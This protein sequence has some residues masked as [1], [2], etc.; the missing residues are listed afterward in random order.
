MEPQPIETI[1]LKNGL[2]L[3]IRDLSRKIAGDRWQVELQARITIPVEARWF[4]PN[5]PAPADIASLCAVL[6]QT[7]RF[8]Y[9]DTRNFIDERE[10]EPLFDSM[11]ATVKQNAL[12]YYEHPDFP[13]R[14]LI[15]QYKTHLSRPKPLADDR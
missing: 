13:A 9:R 4:G 14:Y 3:E 7:T 5:S 2:N 10:K 12:K 11:R 15:R 6:G 1:R 8:E